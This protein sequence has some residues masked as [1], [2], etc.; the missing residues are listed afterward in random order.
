VSKVDNSHSDTVTP[1]TVT[2]VYTGVT[3]TIYSCTEDTEQ[4]QPATPP[5]PDRQITN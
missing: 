4:T 2:V 1:V 3:R 5:G